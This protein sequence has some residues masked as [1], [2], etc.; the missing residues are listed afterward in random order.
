MGIP[1]G[2][3][4]TGTK[5]DKVCDH[6]MNTI[7]SKWT[8]VISTGTLIRSDHMGAIFTHDLT[9]LVEDIYALR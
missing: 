2:Q 8:E 1:G 4:L 3:G 5:G 6:M 7:I 9:F